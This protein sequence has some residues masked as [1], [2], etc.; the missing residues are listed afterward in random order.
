TKKFVGFDPANFFSTPDE[1]K[2][3]FARAA[4][5]CQAPRLD[6]D[7][8]FAAYASAFPNEA[9]E[10]KNC[11]AGELPAGWDAELASFPAGTAVA[12]RNA[13]GKALNAFATKIPWIVGGDARLSGSTLTTL[14]EPGGFHR[15]RARGPH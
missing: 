8:R 1:A 4:Q 14:E 5:R 13:G 12:S 9:A 6:W 11:T 3:E 15:A 10:F 7:R 2:R